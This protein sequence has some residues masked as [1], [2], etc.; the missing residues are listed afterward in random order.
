MNNLDS[1]LKD[2]KNV[3]YVDRV[4]NSLQIL[5]NRALNDLKT[6]KVDLKTSELRIFSQ[7]G[8]DGVIDA[9][10]RQLDIKNKYF[11]EFGV[12]DGWSCNTRL[13]AEV[14]DWNGLYIEVKDNDYLALRERYKH[15]NKVN[16]L[17]A[18]VNPHNINLIF[19][20]NSVPKEFG[21]LSIDIDGQ[22]Y[23][24]WEALEDLYRPDIVIV[25]FNSFHDPDSLVVEQAGL[26]S[27]GAI[28]ETWGCSLGALKALSIRK[29]YRLVH[30]E[31]AGLNAFFV[32]EEL[33][34]KTNQ[35][36]DGITRRSPNYGLRGRGHSKLVQYGES[37]IENRPTVKV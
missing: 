37:E 27:N 6:N 12:G 2:L 19:N 7:N 24:V 4:Y 10:L 5:R 1:F 20:D 26:P 33:I 9:L 17:K 22:D 14:F 8:E 16:C 23:Y 30:V 13:L 3:L 31:M 36:F 11:V 32:K 35:L 21:V 25:E 15:S 18:A 29:G 28:T 34:A